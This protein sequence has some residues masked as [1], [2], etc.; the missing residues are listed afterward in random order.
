MKTFTSVAQMKLAFLI[1]GQQVETSGYYAPGDS[2]GARYL[3]EGA[4]AVDGFGDHTLAGGTVAILQETGNIRHYGAVDDDVTDNVNAFQAAVDTGLIIIPETASKWALAAS[5]TLDNPCTIISYGRKSTVRQTSWGVPVFEVRSNDISCSTHLYLET[6]EIRTLFDAAALAA[7]NN[8][9]AVKAEVAVDQKAAGSAIYGRPFDNVYFG[10]LDV[11]GFI[12]GILFAFGNNWSVDQL[13]VE[14]VDFGTFGQ[15][16]EGC[17]VGPSNGITILRSQ[18]VDPHLIYF[19]GGALNIGY[20]LTLGP[21]TCAGVEDGSHIVSLK[22]QKNFSI[23]SINGT[24]SAA[25]IIAGN[26]IGS[27]LTLIESTG[28]LNGYDVVATATAT[29]DAAGS[30][31]LVQTNSILNCGPGRFHSF[32][33]NAVFSNAAINVTGGGV[34]TMTSPDIKMLS[35]T[36]GHGIRA[37]SKVYIHN[38]KIEYLTDP[39]LGTG[40]SHCFHTDSVSGFMD[41]NLPR[42]IGTQNL[43]R[44]INGGVYEMLLDQDKIEDGLDDLSITTNTALYNTKFIGDPAVAIAFVDGDITPSVRAGTFFKTANTAG[45][46]IEDFD[47]GSRGQQITVLIDDVN[48]DFDFTASNL[49]IDGGVDWLTS[50]IGDYL[51]AKYDEDNNVWLCNK[52]EV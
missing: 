29:N 3:I 18:G 24:T 16:G 51:T 49:K 14:D 52:Y 13:T 31:V 12:A 37:S 32:Q 41:I 40:N 27:M 19:P 42:V 25:N 44:G 7:S 48:T 33:S 23:E 43:F 45:K 39:T 22:Y 8:S 2:G 6:T 47:L 38:P 5:V 46:I 17:Q 4:Q 35:A 36:P 9:A 34:L 28:K 11:K 50:G 15:P 26:H 30:G 20:G 10:H 1:A 21:V